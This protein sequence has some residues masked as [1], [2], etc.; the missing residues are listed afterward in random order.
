MLPILLTEWLMLLRPWL[1]VH[2]TTIDSKPEIWFSRRDAPV[3]TVIPTCAPHEG[4][5]PAG[6]HK[7]HEVCRMCTR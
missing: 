2:L 1:K 3:S 4:R 5:C 7:G 6:R